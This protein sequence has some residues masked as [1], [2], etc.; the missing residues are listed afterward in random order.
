VTSFCGGLELG[1]SGIFPALHTSCGGCGGCGGCICGGWYLP[2]RNIPAKPAEMAGFL[3]AEV[4]RRLLRRFPPQTP[5]ARE[6]ARVGRAD[7]ALFRADNRKL[8][9]KV[10][11]TPASA[12]DAARG[13]ARPPQATPPRPG[14]SP[15][16]RCPS[17]LK[18]PADFRAISSSP[19]MRD[20]P[21]PKRDMPGRLLRGI[22]RIPGPKRD[23]IRP[24]RDIQSCSVVWHVWTRLTVEPG[25]FHDPR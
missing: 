14:V 24:N 3:A 8:Q 10:V 6:R 5:P 7:P 21:R 19:A 22:G 17:L 11:T 2:H 12:A 15:P 13:T 18:T 23:T 9:P 20:R 16:A 1:F 4:V 25:A